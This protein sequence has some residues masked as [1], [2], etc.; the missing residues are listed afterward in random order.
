MRGS[1]S[2]VLPREHQQKMLEIVLGKYRD[3][4]LGAE[5]S[6]DQRLRD[7]THCCMN[8][9]V[10]KRL[11]A[12][13]AVALRRANPIGRGFGPSS[14]AIGEYLRIRTKRLIGTDEHRAI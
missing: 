13:L 7:T 11:P 8:L 10:C 4:P 9:R 1:N 6:I 12:S 3:G 5:S 14:N 2:R